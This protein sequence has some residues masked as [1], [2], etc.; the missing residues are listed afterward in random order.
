LIAAIVLR[1]DGEEIGVA[2][3]R[4]ADS[5]V[6]HNHTRK[7]SEQ[8][9]GDSSIDRDGL[10]FGRH[11]VERRDSRTRT[12]KEVMAAQAVVRETRKGELGYTEVASAYS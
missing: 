11:Q 6:D 4:S 7:D 3:P 5:P 12:R 9:A 10:F 1:D 2:S 8:L